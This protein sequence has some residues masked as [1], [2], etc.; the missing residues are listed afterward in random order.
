MP[1]AEIG[2]SRG[3]RIYRISRALNLDGIAIDPSAE[4]IKQ[5]EQ[6][7]GPRV[8][9]LQGVASDMPIADRSVGLVFF[10]FCLYLT[11]GLEVQS[12][13]SEASRT[14][15]EGGFVAIYDF[16]SSDEVETRYEHLEPLISYRRPYVPLME[17]HGYTLISKTPLSRG[18]G[19]DSPRWDVDV[20]ERKGLWIFTG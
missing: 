18:G 17:T 10:G 13:I 12:A 20:T 14:L 11:N 5:G 8:R 3:D 7:F 4:A 15:A 9:Y 6:L 1:I 19:S 16:D 2:S